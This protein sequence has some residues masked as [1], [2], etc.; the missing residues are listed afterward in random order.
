MITTILT[1]TLSLAV[2][3][4]LFYVTCRLF[5]EYIAVRKLP[6]I[7]VPKAPQPK[8]KARYKSPVKKQAKKQT[9]D[10]AK[11]QPTK[12]AKKKTATRK[13]PQA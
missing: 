10:V 5:S 13:K 9:V 2:I 12:Q 4:S 8:K 3:F 1:Y 7:E 6:P 11:K